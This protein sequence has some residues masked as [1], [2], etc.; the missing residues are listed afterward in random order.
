MDER[1]KATRLDYN[2]HILLEEIYNQ[3]QIIKEPQLVEIVVHDI[4]SGGMGFY[5]KC[6]LPINFYFN[7][8]IDLGE[9]KKFFSVLRIVRKEVSEEGFQY[10]CEFTGLADILMHYFDEYNANK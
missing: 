2:A 10:G 7:A 9:S 3:D 4:S 5:S 8:K 1:R 6:D